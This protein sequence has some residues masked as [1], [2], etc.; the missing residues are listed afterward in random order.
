MGIGKDGILEIQKY[1]LNPSTNA[2]GTINYYAL[3]DAGNWTITN[4]PALS[5]SLKPIHGTGFISVG[6]FDG[7]GAVDYMLHT[8]S[9]SS[10]N[11]YISFPAKSIFNASVA[12][13]YIEVPTNDAWV[14]NDAFIIDFDGDGKKD[15][16]YPGDTES[17]VY[18]FSNSGGSYHFDLA[19]TL[20]YPNLTDCKNIQFGDFNGDGKTDV[21]SLLKSVSNPVSVVWLIQYS[22]GKGLT[23]PVVFSEAQFTAGGGSYGLNWDG[24][25][26]NLGTNYNYQFALNAPQELIVSDYN[27]DGKSDVLFKWNHHPGCD[28]NVRLYYSTGLSFKKFE[29]DIGAE[30]GND[31]MVGDFNGDGR[32]DLTFYNT[33]SSSPC[34]TGVNVSTNYQF[35]FNPFGQER[36]LH[37]ISDAF[38]QIT[39]FSYKPLTDPAVHVKGT[40]HTYPVTSIQIPMYVVNNVAV[41]DG[42][43]GVSATAYFYTDALVHRA[44]KYT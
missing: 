25:E 27:G 31:C 19:A 4:F 37:K 34:N 3:D 40:S 24:D 26:E 2:I 39:Q 36:L 5:S 43:G 11:S 38:N 20:S 12:T 42:I 14:F 44:G 7:D 9:G 29:M 30:F 13:P 35:S 28:F 23:D 15:V 17:K 22:T 18:T 8:Y 6:D 32:A 10:V 21:L 41:P 1:C 16:F 33:E